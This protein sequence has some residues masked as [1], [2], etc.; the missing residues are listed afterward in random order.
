VPPVN[1]K[2][3]FKHEKSSV[4]VIELKFRLRIT[5]QM[6]S[7]RSRTGASLSLHH[8]EVGPRMDIQGQV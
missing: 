4:A 1:E 3:P 5:S 8:G 2:D 7:G 6:K